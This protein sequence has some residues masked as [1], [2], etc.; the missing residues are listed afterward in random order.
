MYFYRIIIAENEK[1]RRNYA[2]MQTL[3]SERSSE[4]TNIR[5]TR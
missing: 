5:R 2:V 1:Y 4:Y 3:F